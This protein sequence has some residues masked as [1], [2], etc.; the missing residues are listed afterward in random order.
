MEGFQQYILSLI[1]AALICA[2]LNGFVSDGSSRE[3]IRLLCGVYLLITVAGPLPG[4]KTISL[5]D[6]IAI[7]QQEADSLAK[8][9]QSQM[10]QAFSQIIKSETEAYIFDKASKYDADLKITVTISKDF[11]PVSAEL[12]GEIPTP[13]RKELE[14]ILET[15]LGITKEHQIWT[16]HP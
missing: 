14:K 8:E 1:I 6:Y 15:E 16:G 3:W 11:L 7:Y 9:G 2:V 12:E 4:F 5:S 13:S 10:E